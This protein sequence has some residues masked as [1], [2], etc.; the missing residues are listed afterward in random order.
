VLEMLVGMPASQAVAAGLS[1][2][3]SLLRRNDQALNT[4]L[5]TYAV[6]SNCTLRAEMQTRSDGKGNDE[7]RARDNCATPYGY[8]SSSW[9]NLTGC[10]RLCVPANLGETTPLGILNFSGTIM[11]MMLTTFVA[12]VAKVRTVQRCKS[13][14]S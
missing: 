12:V 2:Y 1:V 10:G 8:P 6:V 5:K 14:E 9:S 4:F 3:I 11:L 13:R 7:P